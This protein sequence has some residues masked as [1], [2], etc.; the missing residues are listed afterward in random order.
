VEPSKKFEWL[1]ECLIH[2]IGRASMKSEEIKTV[3][4]EGKK[5]VRAYNL[6]DGI[7]TQNE[8]AAKA[9]LD[10][11]NFSRSVDR[12]AKSGIVFRF[13]EGNEVKFL[14]IFPIPEKSKRKPKQKKKNNKK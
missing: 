10:Q 4:G 5:Q 7:L 2:V 6:C 11:G 14:H 9:G 1:L 13:K 8:I 12:W 3:V